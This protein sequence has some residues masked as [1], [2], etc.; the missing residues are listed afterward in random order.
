LE[1]R[2]QLLADYQAR[3]P[4]ILAF[5]AERLHERGDS[6]F[7]AFAS[8]LRD[9]GDASD[10]D[11]MCL[12]LCWEAGAW[13]ETVLQNVEDDNAECPRL[14]IHAIRINDLRTLID[15]AFAQLGI[16]DVSDE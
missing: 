2:N 13:R 6:L 10:M 5:T 15:G 9:R 1:G 3:L 4:A 8:Y 12:S 16:E 7:G 11:T 14:T